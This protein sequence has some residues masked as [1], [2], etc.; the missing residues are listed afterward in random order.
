[1]GTTGPCRRNSFDHPPLDCAARPWP[2]LP[3]MPVRA[4]RRAR[5]PR[6]CRVRPA[7]RTIRHFRRSTGQA[8]RR[9]G[10]SAGRAAVRNDPAFPPVNG[11]A[12]SAFVS[13]RRRGADRRRRIRRRRLRRA[14]RRP[15]EDCMKDSAAARRG[16]EA[17][18]A[19]QGGQRPARAARRSLQADRAI[20]ARP[21]SR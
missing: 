6:R 15:R 5:F 4:W 16:R 17:R 3:P 13:G 8:G 10:I 18:Q 21:K 14:G 11:A 1:M 7:P 19:D 9:P 2:S 20:S 12:P